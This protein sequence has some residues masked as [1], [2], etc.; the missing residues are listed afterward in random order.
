MRFRDSMRTAVA[1]LRHAKVRSFL[2]MLGIVIGIASVILIMSI[3]SS[4]QKYIVGQ[5]ESFGSNLIS[6]Q[7]GAP[8]NGTPASVQG[9]IIKT[10]TDRDVEALRNEPS[11]LSV[12]P[13]VRGQARIIF[14][15]HDTS[16]VWQA[17]S[18]D[19]FNIINLEFANGYPFS[20]SD[21]KSYNHV[22][23]LGSKLAS[24]LFE[25]RNPVGKY[26]RLKDMN[27][28]VVGVLKSKGAGIF[29]MD[30]V[31]ILPLTVG[32]KQ[33]LGIDYYQELAIQA[34]DTYDVSF[35]KGRIT[36]VLRANHRITNPSKDDFEVRSQEEALKL[37]GNITSVLTI[38]LSA[39]AAISLVVG[40]I[41]IMN[42]ML[43]S[44][45]ER[46]REIG[47]RK[48]L[49]ATSS[50][51]L[52]QFLWEAILLTFVGGVAGI[53]IGAFFVALLYFIMP[54]FLSVGWVFSLPISA[55]LLAVGV[56][57]LTGV[58]FG[59]YPARQASK[60]SPIEALRY[61]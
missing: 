1:G 57:T 49:G 46:T 38:F 14:E 11:V 20:E 32:Q 44:V 2:T 37:L 55:I 40:G 22:V 9:I 43:V 42:I 12:A 33:L 45:I 52:Q 23:I 36:S 34:A 25:D 60:K 50:D 8:I 15:N 7:P 18:A 47:L 53:A 19:I 16:V 61:E 17:S 41:G 28:R 29:S 3:G 30:Q 31:A 5:V 10:L 27:F 21:V 51:I 48:A 54:L 56:S 6:V 4:A 24:D 13:M 58:V 35:T 59:L 39:I 26:V